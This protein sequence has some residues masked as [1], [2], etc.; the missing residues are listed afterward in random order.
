MFSSGW[1]VGSWPWDFRMKEGNPEIY[2]QIFI[3]GW[4]HVSFRQTC[5]TR[6]GKD[7]KYYFAKL[8]DSF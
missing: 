1:D 8:H 4:D 3:S 5:Y 7:K 6:R 2:V